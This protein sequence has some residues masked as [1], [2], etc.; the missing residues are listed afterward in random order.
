MSIHHTPEK[1][2]DAFLPFPTLTEE[3]EMKLS[4]GIRIKRI[5][6]DMYKFN[7]VVNSM[8]S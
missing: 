6:N 3:V 7:D 4:L 8:M 5:M 2:E 1:E